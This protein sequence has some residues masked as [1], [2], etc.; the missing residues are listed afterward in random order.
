MMDQFCINRG[1]LLDNPGTETLKFP[2]KHSFHCLLD[3]P[4]CQ[5]S[6]YT[7]LGPKNEDTGEHCIGYRIHSD[8]TKK[9]L[10][11]GFPYGNGVADN[12]YCSGC[13]GDDSR[14]SFGWVATVKGIVL[15][16]GQ[17]NGV[18][19]LASPVIGSIEILDNTVECETYVDP[20]TCGRSLESVQAEPPNPS[21]QEDPVP[22]PV[23]AA[24][25]TDAVDCSA[26]F[27]DAD[28][29]GG[30][31]MKYKINVP[32]DTSKK[33]C[34]GC[35]MSVEM[36]YDGDAW[37]SLGFST[38]GQMIGSDAVIGIPGSGVSKYFMA[39]MA[40]SQ[41]T[42]MPESQQTLTDSSVEFDGQQTVMKF[43]KIMD[44]PG[45]VPIVVGDNSFLWAYGS[46]PTLGYHA[47]RASFALNLSIGSETTGVDDADSI[48][49]GAE[50]TGVDD[51][52]S[53]AVGDEVCITGY[54]M[55]QFCINRGELLDNPGT[56]TLKFP[57]K[58]SFHCLLD[59]PRC[60]QS[61]YT[62]LGPKNEDTGEHC[63]GYRIHSDETK[64]VL[65]AGFPYGNGVADNGYCSGC[66]GD[67]SR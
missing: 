16:M 46:S 65:D 43:T 13:T 49:V 34:A 25:T 3:V 23:P 60:Q 44:E 22:A 12:G 41:V 28:L 32:Q 59:V 33:E 54:M 42:K 39:G 5:Q 8:E 6:G 9:V 56:E 17:E 50:T 53:I 26:Q 55:D 63:I 29:T 58:H 14:P 4:R 18:N 45:E 51:A 57:E 40:T 19:A 24:P 15:E 67:D 35:T 2:E 48:A 61:G 38:N 64:K 27:C 52:D 62:V 36:S 47:N 30:Y 66:T 7:V 10:D 1:E 21:K 11:A 37:I 20:P 31:T